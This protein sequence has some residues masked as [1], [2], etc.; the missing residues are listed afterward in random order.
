MMLKTKYPVPQIRDPFQNLFGRFFGD[1]LADFY[2]AEAQGG[3][4]PRMNISETENAYE[5]AFELPGVSES[6]IQVQLHENILTVTA[7]RKDEREEQD[8]EQ[9]SGRRWHRVEH[10][11]GEYSRAITLP[12]DATED[13]IEAVYRAGVLKVIVPKQPAPQPARITVR[14]E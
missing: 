5:M 6:D 12:K 13:G 2:G 10:R 9:K 1:A 11:Y 4:V 3:N 8:E 14:S 7:S